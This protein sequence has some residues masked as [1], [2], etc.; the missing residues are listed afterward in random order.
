MHD[1][2]YCSEGNLN[3]ASDGAQYLPT[4]S[5]SANSRN[6]CKAEDVLTN[7]KKTFLRDSILVEA[8]EWFSDTLS[9]SP[10]QGNLILNSPMADFSCFREGVVYYSFKCCE[11]L[12]PSEYR[13]TGVANADFLLHVTARPTGGSTIAWALTCQSD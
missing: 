11:S 2:F 10:V 9:V 13:T 12:M 3:C 6:R 4:L 1:C 8:M 7:E 5:T